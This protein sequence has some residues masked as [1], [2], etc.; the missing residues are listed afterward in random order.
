MSW[1]LITRQSLVGSFFA[2]TKDGRENKMTATIIVT[3]T[4]LKT[5]ELKRIK[6]KEFYVQRR[7]YPLK[8]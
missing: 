6:I 5:C 1:L 4:H 3:A 7:Y 8:R 2:P